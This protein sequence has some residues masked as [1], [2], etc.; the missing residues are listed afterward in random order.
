MASETT[1]SCL[2]SETS[3][4]AEAEA[5]E[6][7]ID[8]PGRSSTT[9]AQEESLNRKFGGIGGS[10]EILALCRFHCHYGRFY[11]VAHQGNRTYQPV[12][13]AKIIRHFRKHH[14]DIPVPNLG[15]E[16]ATSQ[17]MLSS[18]TGQAIPEA[19]RGSEKPGGSLRLSLPSR[20]EALPTNH[21]HLDRVNWHVRWRAR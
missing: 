5:D 3:E 11:R 19:S 16:Y 21:W 14:P 10:G 12:S 9:E 7:G 6:A 20:Y 17:G 4:N 13:L 15:I 2:Q 1:P 8:G 18:R